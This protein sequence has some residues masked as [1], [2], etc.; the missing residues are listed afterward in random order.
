MLN[1]AR[2]QQGE[3][4][5]L[6][7]IAQAEAVSE[8]YLGQ[9]I[10]PLKNAGLLHAVRGAHGGYRLGRSPTDITIKEIVEVL[11]GRIALVEC[12]PHSTYCQRIDDCVAHRLWRELNER[13]KDFLQG[14]TLRDLLVKKN[15][16]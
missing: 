9:L 2:R 14:I 12:V 4:V 7:S 13:I 15:F 8:K 10:I 6:K 5:L 11:E 3:A 16:N 1:L